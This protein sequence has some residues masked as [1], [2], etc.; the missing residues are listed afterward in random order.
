M[1][2][3]HPSDT[4]GERER[5][6]ISRCFCCGASTLRAVNPT[7]VI[8]PR[9]SAATSMKTHRQN[10]AAEL[11]REPVS[12]S[13]QQQIRPRTQIRQW[14]P[15]V[16]TWRLQMRQTRVCQPQM[17]FAEEYR[18]HLFRFHKQER[19]GNT[20]TQRA[21]EGVTLPLYSIIILEKCV[22]IKATSAGWRP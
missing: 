17:S 12:Q 8:L 7:V 18:S 6:R 15:L 9:P 2:T 16:S 3:H 13:Q 5:E 4:E 21:N 22:F 20:H 11:R 10:T 19:K 1:I 14:R